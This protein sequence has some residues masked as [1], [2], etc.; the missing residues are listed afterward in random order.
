MIRPAL[1]QNLDYEIEQ[2]CE[3]GSWSPNWSWF[4]QFPEEWPT[5][6][7]E[8]RGVLTLRTLRALQAFG[9]LK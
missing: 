8:W 5:A 9:R 2:Q 6:E 7:R 3:D 1:E 4:G